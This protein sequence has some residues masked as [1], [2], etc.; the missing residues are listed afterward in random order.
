MGNGRA[1]D[2][3][4][5]VASMIKDGKCKGK[6]C[7]NHTEELLLSLGDG[8]AKVAAVA[9]QPRVAVAC[10]ALAVVSSCIS[11]DFDSGARLEDLSNILHKGFVRMANGFRMMDPDSP[12]LTSGL[13]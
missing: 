12:L 13:A 1:D 7:L 6:S 3:M 4:S 9:F 11:T 2:S 10:G 5:T 8:C